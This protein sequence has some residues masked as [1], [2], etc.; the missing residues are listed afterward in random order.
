MSCTLCRN[1]REN[2]T[3]VH[4]FLHFGLLFGLLF[5]SLATI[6]CYK[7]EM[8]IGRLLGYFSPVFGAVPSEK[9]GSP[10]DDDSKNSTHT[11]S[12]S[13]DP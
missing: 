10:N 7:W 3:Q 12:D 9:S 1:I 11:Q 8:E 5:E 13:E 6:L 2:V 4:A